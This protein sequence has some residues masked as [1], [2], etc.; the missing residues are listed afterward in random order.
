MGFSFARPGRRSVSEGVTRNGRRLPESNR[1][2]RLCRR[3]Y[4]ALIW[5][6]HA[7][8]QSRA[9]LCR[10]RPGV[11]LATGRPSGLSNR[12]RLHRLREDLQGS[13]RASA[14]TPPPPPRSVTSVPS[15]SRGSNAT[16]PL[17]GDS[18]T[19]S[20]PSPSRGPKADSAADARFDSPLPPPFSITLASCPLR[21]DRRARIQDR[22]ARRNRLRRAI[23]L[24][25]PQPPSSK[26]G[27]ARGP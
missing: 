2:K 21:E 26:S 23:L 7:V 25:L 4:T 5:L 6:A 20:V 9:T 8:S 10:H 14:L 3:V 16:A 19:P 18:S 11:R 12:R 17:D 1:C 13:R 27:L 15:P 22:I 24:R